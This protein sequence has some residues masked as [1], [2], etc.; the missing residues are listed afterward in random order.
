M[1]ERIGGHGFQHRRVRRS[2]EI[3]W[4]KE[5]GV[6]AVLSLLEAHHNLQAYEEAGLRALHEPLGGGLEGPD[7]IAPVLAAI[8]DGL[9]RPGAVLL[10]HREIVD[11]VLAGILAA[12]LVHAGMVEQPNVATSVI[13]EILGR[14][15]GPEARRLIAGS[16]AAQE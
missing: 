16:P 13:Q 7:D 3:V 10:V 11:D 8:D 5:Q 15:L 1:S 14:P 9:A 2:E 12:Y 4:L 6:T